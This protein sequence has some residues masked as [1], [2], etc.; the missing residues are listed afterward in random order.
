MIEIF[1]SIVDFLGFSQLSS[2]DV[3]R[4]ALSF[5]VIYALY[6]FIKWIVRLIIK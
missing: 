6:K 1:N 3:M 4:Y 5:L 2:T